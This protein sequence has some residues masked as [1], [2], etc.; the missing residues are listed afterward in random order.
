MKR[1]T[2][3]IAAL[4]AAVALQAQAEKVRLLFVG[5]M[6]QHQPQ[7]NA[8]A[9][10]DTTGGYDYSDCFR[11]MTPMTEW[12]DA[13]VCNF[14]VTLAG[15]PY[16][17]YPTFSAPDEF[18]D[19]MVETG[20]DVYLTANNHCC[21]RRQKGL[22]R[23][24]AQ[25]L[26]RNLQ[27]AGTYTDAEDRAERYPLIVERKGMKIAMLNYT[28]GTNG[29]KPTAP[30]VVNYI[31]T[32]QIK[33]DIASAR[34]LEADYIIT[35][36]HWG[37]EYQNKQNAEQTALAYWLIDNG[38]DHV[39]GSHPHVVQPIE[40]YRTPDGREHL[41][42]YSLGNV[43]SN[44]QRPG[45]TGGIA[46]G[47]ELDPDDKDDWE[48]WYKPFHVARPDILGVRNYMVVPVGTPD[49][50][51]PVGEKGLLEKFESETRKLMGE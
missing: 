23:T 22:E 42:V 41:I 4:I 27:Q 33:L 40:K 45:T 14:E 21:D 39:I 26:Q 17:G 35:C 1:I 25:M 37:I 30:N 29:I 9:R 49:D 12:A 50:K 51:M 36:I 32:T 7:I 10:A 15:Q 43:I 11:L 31:D 48:W 47:L 16:K 5:D 18:L 24:I 44:Q 34:H 19:A 38:V 13:S 28:Y 2:T 46:V 3:L 6:M 20:F 8:A